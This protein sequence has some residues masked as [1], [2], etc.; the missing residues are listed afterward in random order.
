MEEK[1]S[2][3]L[4]ELRKLGVEGERKLLLRKFMEKYQKETLPA[5][6]ELIPKEMLFLEVSELYEEVLKAEYE[7]KRLGAFV[8]A[9][10]NFS[11]FAQYCKDTEGTTSTEYQLV[12]KEIGERELKTDESTLRDMRKKYS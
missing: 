9:S 11:A 8:M 3:T 4:D 6:A 5:E 10:G 2:L 1:D 7:A 12:V